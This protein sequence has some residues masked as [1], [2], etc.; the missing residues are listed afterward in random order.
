MVLQKTL[1]EELRFE[2]VGIHTGEGA[3]VLLHPE[4]ENSGICFYRKGYRIPLSPEFV[5]N[6]FH[7][8]DLGVNGTVVRTVEHLLATLHLLGITNLTVEVIGGCEIPIMDGSAYYFYR[9]LKDRIIVQSEEIEPFTV[10]EELVVGREKAFLKVRPSTTL[11]IT[12]EG[13]FKNYMERSRYTFRGNIRDVILART[14]CFEHEIKFIRRKG[15]L[16]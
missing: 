14:F 5:V 15:L 9:E 13:V 11:E 12:Y 7:S 2:G 10:K 3:K 6:T 16:V 1:R 8:T 4:K